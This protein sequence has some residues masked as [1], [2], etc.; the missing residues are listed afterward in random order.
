MTTY[1]ELG[2]VKANESVI[3]ESCLSFAEQTLYVAEYSQAEFNKLFEAVGVEELAVFESTGAEIVYEGATLDAFKEKAKR[4][5]MKIWGAI[6]AAY[7]KVYAFFIQRSKTAMEQIKGL[8]KSDVKKALDAN[9]GKH[10]GT[11]H[12]YKD[13][14]KSYDDMVKKALPL[15]KEVNNEFDKINGLGSNALV[16]G[17][18]ELKNKTTFGGENK[19]MEN[20]EK[21]TEKL[22][23]KIFETFGK[24]GSESYSDIKS[25][26]REQLK[27][28]D[29]TGS[30]LKSNVDEL[31]NIVKGG[32]SID[33]IKKSY[34]EQKK[35][36]DECITKM[37]G[38]QEKDMRTAGKR[39]MVLGKLANA[40]DVCANTY[41]DIF[42]KRF[43]EY[44]LVLVRVW[45][46]C[47]KADKEAAKE[48]EEKANESY[49]YDMVSEA[50]D[51]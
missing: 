24:K 29:V 45:K 44:L 35:Q 1:E 30:W 49:S 34:Q 21:A 42:K 51:W 37:K 12:N 36:I 43:T 17:Y 28:I 32:K 11:V 40:F 27:E 22:L 20:A 3:P 47:K 15:T 18:R 7:E 14:V 2:M 23:T 50:F 5:F 38:L 25:A 8:D 31:V 26:V 10:Y 4:F 46:D 19:V 39:V 48:K 41:F 33:E 13:I 16:A 9:P 6:K